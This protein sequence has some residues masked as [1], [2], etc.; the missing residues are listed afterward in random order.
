LPECGIDPSVLIL[1]D[2]EKTMHAPISRVSR[3]ALA[4]VLT[5]LTSCSLFAAKPTAVITSPPSGSQ[6]Q[7][8]EEVAVQS[9]ATDPAGVVRVELLVD[10]AVVRTDQSPSPQPSFSLIQ[11]WKATAGN[12]TVMVRAYNAAGTA[13]DPAAISLTVLQRVAQTSSSSSASSALPP[14][15]PPPPATQSA[16]AAA[17]SAACV[18]ASAFVADVTVPDG[19]NIAPNQ[20]FS[21]VW[22][23]SNRGTCPWGAG[24]HLVHTSGTA[25]TTSLAVAA[26]N[27]APGATADIAVPLKAPA[28]AGAVTGVWRMRAPSGVLFGNSVT[29]KIN[30]GCSGTPNIPSFTASTT[31]IAP[32][33]S[34]TLN[35]GAVTNADSAEID[36]GIGGVA[37]PGSRSVSPGSTTTYTLTARCGGSVATR[38]VTITVAG[39]PPP[40]PPIGNFS[41]SWFHNFGTMTLTQSGSSVTGTYQN[42]FDG[43]SGTISG[44]VSGNTLTGAWLIAGGTGNLQFTLSGAGNTFD[45]NWDTLNT[46][47]GAKSGVN[48]LSG[49][50][51]SGSWSSKLDLYPSCS[52]N[53]TRKDNSVTGT[54]C[55]GT[56]DG[57]ISYVSDATV[58][59]GS[60]HIGGSSGSIKFYLLGYN[61]TQFQGNYDTTHF[62]CGWRGGA[63]EPGTCLR[64]P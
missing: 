50:S 52:M 57:T 51:F 62:W 3:I 44:T 25:M 43:I 35:W 47:C 10:N 56:V 22:R 12:H 19:T 45:G 4:L 28:S 15:L 16:S 1:H 27:T 33:G 41:G 11:T 13:S 46:W 23:L 61:G 29:V 48:F 38:Q 40:P 24:Y 17:S 54:Y 5:A 14:P 55:N 8:G 9:T 2:R 18:N 34:S 37:T 53:L 7:E 39:L 49:C 6:Y 31:N 36:Q 21:K 63:S 26:P 30:V 59:T 32:G 64:T 58:L 20:E 42:D 60:W